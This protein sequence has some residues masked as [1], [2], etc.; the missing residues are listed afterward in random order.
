MSSCLNSIVGAEL[1]EPLLDDGHPPQQ[2]RQLRERLSVANA[3]LRRETRVIGEIQR[4]L[5]PA[6]LPDIDGFDVAS[7]YRPCALAGGDYYDIVPLVDG[8]WGLIMADVAGHGT[9]S[10]VIMAVMRTL[11]HAH[12]PQ[13]RFLSSCEFLDFMNR[14]VTG[15]Y[16]RDGRFVTVWCAVLEPATRRLTYAS[17]GH[18]PPR[19]LRRKSVTALDAVGGLPLGIEEGSRYEEAGVTL[20]PNDLLVVYTDGVT[21]AMRDICGHREYFA[22]DRLDQVMIE[23]RRD[24]AAGC[25]CRINQAV[26]EFTRADVPMDD[27]TLLVFRAIGA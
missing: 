8:H 26:T 21:E 18:N 1:T 2:L 24:G 3:E 13:T 5:L 10:A 16:T 4:S 6:V 11:V 14:Q 20:E 23:S 7:F 12:L 17:A 22:T 19:L 27:Q 15:V 25:I 9:S